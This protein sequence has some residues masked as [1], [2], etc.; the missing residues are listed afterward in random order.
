M[1]KHCFIDLETT[2]TDPERHAVIQI[3][4]MITQYGKVLDTFDFVVKPFDGQIIDQAA[5]DVNKRTREEIAEFSLP[6]VVQEALLMLFGQHV[7]KYDKYEKM[8]FTAY[9]AHFDYNFLRRL[10][11]NCDDKYFGSWFW[12]PPIDVAQAAILKLQKERPHMQ[13]FKLATVAEKLGIEVKDEELHD[14]MADIS[15]TKEIWDKVT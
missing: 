11:E 14:A 6:D 13:N 5:L 2:G 8:F 15:L 9:Y 12:T 3:A 10:F 4:G 1:S 7:D